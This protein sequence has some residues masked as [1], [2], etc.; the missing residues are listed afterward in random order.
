MALP[1]LCDSVLGH[2]LVAVRIRV[3]GFAIGGC[4]AELNLA[5][6]GRRSVTFL[7]RGRAM[8]PDQRKFG[9]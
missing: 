7:A 4:S 5:G 1:A 6:T 3:A 9:F 8:R 2:E